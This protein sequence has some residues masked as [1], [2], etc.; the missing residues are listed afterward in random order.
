MTVKLASSKL[1]ALSG[2]YRTNSATVHVRIISPPSP[3]P[4]EALTLIS[5]SDK[6]PS[7]NERVLVYRPC[8]ANSDIGPYSVQWGWSAKKDGSHWAHLP[9]RRPPEKEET[10]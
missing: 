5:M 9:D 2:K 1:S 4:N 8:M 3:P 10:L 6:L 7:D